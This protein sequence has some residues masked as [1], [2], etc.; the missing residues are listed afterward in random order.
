MYLPTHMRKMV[1]TLI[2]LLLSWV[3]LIPAQPPAVVCSFYPLQWSDMKTCGSHNAAF[4]G[5]TK[6]DLSYIN[7]YYGSGCNCWVVPLESKSLEAHVPPPECVGD[8]DNVM[9]NI[10]KNTDVYTVMNS[11]CYTCAQSFSQGL[12]FPLLLTNAARVFVLLVCIVMLMLLGEISWHIFSSTAHAYV[13]IMELNNGVTKYKMVS[14]TQ[15]HVPVNCRTRCINMVRFGFKCAFF[16]C[17]V[18]LDIAFV[19]MLLYAFL[20]AWVDPTRGL[21]GNSLLNY[22]TAYFINV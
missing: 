4:M 11:T 21:C 16:L 19:F 5:T 8:H 10:Y 1:F 17:A 2:M 6:L 14:A 15:V 7:K 13:V 3:E 20:F 12:T 22:G 9:Y 18:I